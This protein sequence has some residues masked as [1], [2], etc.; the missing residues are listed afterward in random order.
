MRNATPTPA[1]PSAI[2]SGRQDGY[3]FTLIE[4]LI[5]IVLVGILSAVAVVG[6]SNL[7]SNGGKSACAASAD[8]STVAADEYFVSYGTYPSTFGD[9]TTATG[10][11]TA[12]IGAALVLPSGVTATGLV[13]TP[14]AGGWSLTMTAGTAT[15][16]P[17]FV[18]TAAPAGAAVSTLKVVWPTMPTGQVGVLF[19]T[20]NMPSSLGTSPYAW[21]GPGLPRGL[22]LGP[23]SGTV[24]GT[25]T[26]AGTFPVTFTVTDASA[27]SLSKTYSLTILPASVVC[28]TTIVGWKGEYYGTPDLTGAQA[29]CRDD[30]SVNFDWASAAPGPGLPMDNFS[31]RWSQTL[32]SVG[33]PYTFTLGT[34]DGG[35]LFIDGVL[36]INRWVDQVYPVV[37]PSVTQSLT[38][39]AHSIVVEYYDR[40]AIARATLVIVSPA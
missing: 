40:T 14:T 9:M 24:Y 5:A 10:I 1:R 3:G 34:D 25:P 35:R 30:A 22:G 21:T 7:V 33:G 17:T 16:S 36:V 15:L 27:A 23:T 37:P 39:G 13:A 28:P 26:A 19:T 31:V 8:A 6:I 32:T 20:T 11:G 2:G 38:Q 29:I 4:I 18:C 12:A